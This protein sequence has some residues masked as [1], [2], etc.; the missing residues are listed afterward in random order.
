MKPLSMMSVHVSFDSKTKTEKSVKNQV[1]RRVPVHPVLAK[2]L[3][4]WKLSGW[5]GFMGRKPTAEDLVVPSPR[6]KNRC[7]G[8]GR[9]QFHQDLERL[10][11]RLRRQH[12][13][14][15]TFVSLCRTDGARK[16]LLGWISH[17]A[18]GDIMDTY[19]T[20]P[21]K[22]LC[23]EI[24]KLNIETKKGKLICLPMAAVSNGNDASCGSFTT[25][26]SNHRES[27]GK[28]AEMQGNRTL[29]FPKKNPRRYEAL[30]R[31]SMFT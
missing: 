1:P 23:D 26:D 9:V 24:L 6:G 5:E 29:K 30:Q 7:V 20:F 19:S 2:L 28:V 10:G 17:G 22:A 8:Y 25:L 16:D 15:R 21:W 27:K 3:A 13:L 31:F 11:L 12:D 4:E 14:R 18:C